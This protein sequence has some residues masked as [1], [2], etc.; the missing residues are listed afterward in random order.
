LPAGFELRLQVPVST[1][2]SDISLRLTAT[3]SW[4]AKSRIWVSRPCYDTLTGK[5]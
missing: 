2:K 1:F 3:L 4:K 5:N